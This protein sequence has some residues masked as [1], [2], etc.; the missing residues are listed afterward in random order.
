MTRCLSSSFLQILQVT[1][2][3]TGAASFASFLLWLFC[4]CFFWFFV[5]IYFDIFF[6][7]KHC[8][9]PIRLQMSVLRNMPVFHLLLLLPAHTDRSLHLDNFGFKHQSIPRNNF[10]L[11]FCFIDSCKIC[12]LSFHSGCEESQ[13]HRSVPVLPRSA[14]PA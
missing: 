1:V 12:R 3:T 8:L 11:E 7:K 4:L 14:H 5:V 13:P 2:S 6:I 10:L 9:S